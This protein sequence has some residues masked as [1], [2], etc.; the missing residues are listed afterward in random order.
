MYHERGW[1]LID[2]F[3]IADATAGFQTM[4]DRQKEKLTYGD[5]SYCSAQK[6]SAF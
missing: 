4:T 2:A 3:Y 6:L 5:T 1:N